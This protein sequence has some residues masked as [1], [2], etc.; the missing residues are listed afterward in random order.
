MKDQRILAIGD[1]HGGYRA[2]IQ[3]LERAQVT[4]NDTLIFLGDYVD[5]WS[6]S[7]KVIDY[8]IE[9]NKTTKCIFIK[10]NHD[11]LALN[12]LK[13]RQSNPTWLFHGGQATID[14]Y[15]KETE[16]VIQRHI[17]FIE[18]LDDYYLDTENRLFLHAGFTNIRGIE[19][20]YFSKMFY[21][22]RSLW[23]M[24]LCLNPKLTKENKYYPDRLKLYHEIYIGHTPTV[25]IGETI[26]VNAANVWNVDTG[27]AFKGPLTILDV[28]TKEFWQSDALNDLYPN[29]NGRNH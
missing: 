11:D 25:R 14:S 16:T 20:E 21:W 18:S 27:A 22:D 1:I 12:W 13:H 24:A 19:H 8:L 23:E 17:A 3:A 4:S 10:G 28:D 6:E 7:A 29:E 15:E 26:P 5:G 9:L 2:L